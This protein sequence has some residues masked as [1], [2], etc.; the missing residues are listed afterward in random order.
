LDWIGLD[1]IGLDWIGL[2]WIGLDW[3]GPCVAALCNRKDV[4]RV[5]IESDSLEID[6]ACTDIR[7]TALEAAL[8]RNYPDIV[9]ILGK[10]SGQWLLEAVK[11]QE[12]AR[13]I[14]MVL[15]PGTFLEA[16]DFMGWTALHVAM[17]TNQSDVVI[18]CVSASTMRSCWVDTNETVVCY[19]HWP[20]QEPMRQW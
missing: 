1:W 10:I 20:R 5:L 3:I 6:L 4:V 8:E 7:Q 18:V 12:L 17:K 13:V 14:E 11:R 15:R 16:P 19:R 2:D 9:T